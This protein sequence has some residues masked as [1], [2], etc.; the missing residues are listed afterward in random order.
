ML[1]ILKKHVLTS[2]LILISTFFTHPTFA[3][4][5]TNA[6]KAIFIQAMEYQDYNN[7]SALLLAQKGF[8]LSKKVN[9]KA[10][11][12]MAF[13]RFGALMNIKGE[14]D[15]ALMYFRSALAIRKS[16]GNNASTAGLCF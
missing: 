14:T 13:M 3:Q 16:L 1:T 10:G 8:N 4:T 9:Y 7:D 6:I 2:C 12:G 11:I 15:S 5:D